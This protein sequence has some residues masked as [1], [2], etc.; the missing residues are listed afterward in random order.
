MSII[1]I[2]SIPER[3]LTEEASLYH[4]PAHAWRTSEPRPSQN[5]TRLRVHVTTSV[6]SL[7]TGCQPQT[8][9]INGVHHPARLSNHRIR[10]RVSADVKCVS[11]AL[12][13]D[14]SETFKLRDIYDK[15][16]V[17]Q[18]YKHS[19]QLVTK[20]QLGQM[21]GREVKLVNFLLPGCISL[22]HCVGGV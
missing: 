3:E 7:V 9:E 10:D 16:M 5:V 6:I 22:K 13:E 11:V 20:G 21:E 4:L 12:H 19:L 14:L 15:D 17:I 1:D 18:K 8:T 2:F